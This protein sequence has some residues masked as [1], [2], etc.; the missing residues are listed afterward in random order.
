MEAAFGRILL[1]PPSL[2]TDLIEAITNLL[3]DGAA[4]GPNLLQGMSRS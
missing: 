2:T 3:I 1:S 4:H